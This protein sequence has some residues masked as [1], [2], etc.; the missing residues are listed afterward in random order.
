M[1][2]MVEERGDAEQGYG[3]VCGLGKGNEQ[4]TKEQ[5]LSINKKGPF[6]S[7]LF[8]SAL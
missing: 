8:L 4:R 7:S 1:G 5:N 6:H 2:F 3:A